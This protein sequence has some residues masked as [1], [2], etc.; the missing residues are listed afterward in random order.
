MT[1]GSTNRA[2]QRR[3][4]G[5]WTTLLVLLIAATFC[6]HAAT[7]HIPRAE[8][9]TQPADWPDMR[10]NINTADAAQFMVLPGIG[11]KLAEAI[12]ADR[13]AHGPF[14]SIDDLD[15]VYRIGPKTIDRFRAYVVVDS[16][17]S[18]A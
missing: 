14:T 17:P 15:R 6:A 8:I 9:T 4:V 1:S 5:A 2:T 10:L 3:P 11:P 16:P 12:V 18:D 13:N 7:S